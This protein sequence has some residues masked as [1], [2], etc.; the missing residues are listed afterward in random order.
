[1]TIFFKDNMPTG[2]N[3][4]F[5]TGATLVRAIA[6]AVL[7]IVAH[8][9]VAAITPAAWGAA[10]P[11][12][13]EERQWLKQ[14]DGKIVVNNESG[15]PPIIDTDAAGNP[16]GIVMDYQRL[17]EQKLNFTFKMDKPDSWQNFM[18]RFRNGEIDVN[19]NLQE[20]PK[21]AEYALFTRPYIKISN[22]IIVRKDI[23]GPLSLEDMRGMKIAV[24]KDFAIH[25]H[26]K[27]NYGYLQLVPLDGDLRCL[28]ETSTKSVDASVVNL[29]AA[30]YIIEKMGI[31]NLRVAGNTEYVNALAF[32]SRKDLPILHRILDKGLE[33]IT[34]TER[35]AIYRK[36]ISLGY[37][38]FYKSRQF[39]IISGGAAVLA[40]IVIT[41]I[42][43]WNR[44]L[45]RQIALRTLTLEN[46]NVQLKNEIDERNQAKNALRESEEKYRLI[47]ENQTDLVVKVDMEGRFLFVSPSY[48]ELFGKREGELL[49]RNFMP[50]VHEDDRESTAREM[51]RLFQPPYSAYME[52]RAMTKDGW[53]WLG[54]Q[55]TAILD[56]DNA[57]VAIVGVGRDITERKRAEAAQHESEERFRTLVE[58]SPLGISLIS[59]DGRYKYFNPQF[60]AVFGYTLEDTPTGADWFNKA[61]PD[62]DYRQ[63]VISTWVDDRKQAGIGQARPRI[64]TVT[65]GDGSK[66]EI[67]F[68][69][70]TMENGDQFVIYEDITEKSKMERQLQ[71]TQK[72]EA[73]G[74]LAGGIA[75][76]F[77]NLLM[78]I[79]GRSSLMSVDLDASHPHLEHINAIEEYIRSAAELTRQLLGFARGGKYEVT[80]IDVN[81]LLLGSATMFGRTRKEIKIHTKMQPSPLVV[82]ADKRQ[83]EQVLLNLYVNAW[84][85][86]PD[87][88]ELYLET[89]SA[90]LDDDYCRPYQTKPGPYAKIS[91]TDTGIG[92]NE[93]TRRR[94]FDPFFTT[95]EKSRGVGLG[96]ASAYGIIQNHGGIITVYS[97]RNHG[98]T[99]NIYLQISDKA[100]HPEVPVEKQ[101]LKG[102][103]TILL[104]DDEAMILDVGKAMLAK[105]G[106]RVIACNNGADAIEKVTAMG[107]NIDLVVLDLIMPGMDGGKTFDRIREIMP[108]MTVILS[109]G[110]AI[111]GQATDIMRRGCNGFIQKPFNIS[112]L[113]RKIRQVLDERKEPTPKHP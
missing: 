35:E 10:D 15:W 29:A 104:V 49:H 94:V 100:V 41:A 61:F 97:E 67:H 86:M 70:V 59:H 50:L 28:L 82:E 75:H 5:N 53:R 2:C 54:W 57:L 19:N 43:I 89:N 74:T 73:I 27:N 87:G 31:T 52:Q 88:G 108:E 6:L 79:Q 112:E 60:S 21:R 109:S 23:K 51:A 39:W 14:H 69:P 105:L 77:N 71:Q 20:N 16:F 40:L 47:V 9:N 85:A 110:Y 101:I 83:I 65:C 8:V 25:E 66:K 24:T 42:L 7:V 36:W 17:I 76:D 33:L 106:Y 99:F 44:S 84:Q 103:E 32:A 80:P 26:I 30:S 34:Q 45:K 46:I 90:V 38:P 98:T 62:A 22:V 56:D 92:M 12:T 96:L 55:D 1:M 111:N 93:S 113:S 64:F 68:R 4:H 102:S 13:P 11:L 81:E 63:A 58:K 48:C 3:S 18:E 91:V 107:G 72:F 78:G 95:K 37:V